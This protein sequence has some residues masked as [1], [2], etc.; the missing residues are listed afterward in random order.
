MY[1]EE[2]ND[3]HL[4]EYSPTQ[5]EHEQKTCTYAVLKQQ[6]TR[7]WCFP[8]LAW[9]RLGLDPVT[10]LRRKMDGWVDMV[11]K[12]TLL[13]HFR[14][15]AHVPCCH[16][17]STFS[18]STFL[19]PSLNLRLCHFRRVVNIGCFIGSLSQKN[20]YFYPLAKKKKKASRLD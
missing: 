15:I 20:R 19:K 11:L 6:A 9:R 7:P 16:F 1:V 13:S 5:T 10:P 4:T 14:D 8:P 12:W 2:G 3:K 18:F 17:C